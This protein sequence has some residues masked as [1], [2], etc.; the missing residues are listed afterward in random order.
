MQKAVFWNDR[1]SVALLLDSGARIDNR[2]E[3]KTALHVATI[4]GHA[5]V[6]N[7]LIARGAD[8]ALPDVNG[9]LPFSYAADLAS[10]E[11]AIALINAGAPLNAVST[12]AL[13][14]AAA[15]SN[16]VIN[17]LL[18]HNINVR[19]LRD[20]ANESPC[21]NAAHRHRLPAVFDLLVN[22]VGVD[23]DARDQ[24]RQTCAHICTFHGDEAALRLC[25]AAGANVNPRDVSGRSP[26]HVACAERREKTAWLLLVAGA[27]VE[28]QDDAGETPLHL[29]Y[30]VPG[31]QHLSFYNGI[32]ALVAAGALYDSPLD[33]NGRSPRAVANDRRFWVLA[34]DD[35]DTTGKTPGEIKADQYRVTAAREEVAALQATLAAEQPTGP[36]LCKRMLEICIGLQ[37][38]KISALEMCEILNHAC[39][40][41]W[42]P[43]HRVWKTA[44]TV[45]HFH[46]RK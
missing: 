21:H 46:D 37:M 25:L 36:S 14:H 27:D 15:L 3:G 8:L 7:L 33:H 4:A 23:L 18:A 9:S 26:L 30:S 24:A 29:A 16:T 28:A 10:D 44:T 39:P 22:G 42:V 13:C 34:V 45:K 38:L 19:N 43:F 31:R 12:T 2:H 6:V 11:I 35:I 41:R 1:Q 32:R 5:R 17:M 20:S 40:S